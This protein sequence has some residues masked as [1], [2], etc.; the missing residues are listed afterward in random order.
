MFWTWIWKFSFS[1]EQ[2]VVG[3][4]F[5]FIFLFFRSVC[6]LPF[7]CSFVQGKRVSCFLQKHLSREALTFAWEAKAPGFWLPSRISSILSWLAWGAAE[8]CTAWPPVESLVFVPSVSHSLFLNVFLTTPT[9]LKSWRWCSW[10]YFYDLVVSLYSI[11]WE[12]YQ[13]SCWLLSLRIF[14]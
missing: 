11:F 1:V 10:L 13:L 14:L 5:Y 9:P 2:P 3:V 4:A 8:K 6:L 12:K 7:I